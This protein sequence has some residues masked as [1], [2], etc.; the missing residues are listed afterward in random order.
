MMKKICIPSLL[1]F[2]MSFVMPW[3]IPN[4]FAAKLTPGDCQTIIANAVD[5]ADVTPSAFRPGA[6]T[7]MHIACVDREGNIKGFA[8]MPDAWIGSIDIAKAKAYTAAAFSSNQNALT[9][10]DIGVASQP[11]G[12]LWHIGNSND[13]KTPGGVQERGIIEFP[14]GLPLYK[15][16]KLVGGIGVS[17][18]GVVQDEDVAE[19]GSCDFLPATAIRS[20]TVL[21]GI[22]PYTSGGVFNFRTDC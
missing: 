14:G 18:D 11:G 16:G 21:P 15:D 10:R 12:P 20:D 19:A 8:S 22:L 1:L 3:A 6:M 13:P 9:T 7:K 4:T 2:M 5:Q 17:G